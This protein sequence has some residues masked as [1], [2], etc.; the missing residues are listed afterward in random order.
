MIRHVP[1]VRVALIAA[2]VAVLLGA[3]VAV[4]VGTSSS[5]PGRVPPARVLSAYETA[6]PGN[7][8]DRDCGFS[9]PLPGSPGRLLW[10]F[11][12]TVWEGD[13]P[14]LWLGTT[15]A[16][17]PAVPGRVPGE[18]T[19]LPTPH[20]DPHARPSHRRP[21]GRSPSEGRARPPQGMLAPPPGLVLPGGGTCQVPDVAYGASWA[22]GAARPPGGDTLLIT[23]TDVCVHGAT[24]SVQ[25][26]GVVGYRPGGNVLTGRTRLFSSPGGL[27]FQH[28]LG[29]PVF[30][31]GH[32]YL[33]ASVCDTSAF[34]ICHGGR[35]T[36]ARVPADPAA[37]R[38]PGAYRYWTPEG[39]TPDAAQART[40]V[41]GAAPYLI[42]VAD[43]S[44]VGQGLVMVEQR[45]LDGRFRL[46]RAPA[47]EG[48]WTAAG[49]RIVPCSGGSGLN[50][51]R[52]LIGHPALSTRDALMLSYYDP[53]DRHINARAVPW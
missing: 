21:G 37:W 52:A 13:R 2:A 51:C 30:A 15:A 27:P 36:L 1:R 14:G 6:A 44:A 17:G 18:L 22:S 10:L 19:E 5:P 41:V 31:G 32:L 47:P 16:T 43:Y 39:W 50:Q 23:Y 12:D 25:G 28:N 33:F 34:G 4:A 26:F 7:A 46:W 49:D 53:A 42:H 45:G 24:I 29:S 35:V 48:P 38:D 9:A 40:V 8:I 20:G 3:V 11:C